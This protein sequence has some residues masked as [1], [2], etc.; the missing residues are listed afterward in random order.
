MRFKRQLSTLCIALTAVLFSACADIRK[1]TYP[2]EITYI[3]RNELRSA[4][5]RM[6]SALQQL[7]ALIVEETSVEPPHQKIMHQLGTIEHA[8]NDL[9]SGNTVTNHKAIDEHMDQFLADV[10]KARLMANASPPNYYYAGRLSGSCG[11]CHQFR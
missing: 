8:A 9:A 11:A 3:D 10:A 7:D 1:L 6:A 4:M 2:P 5:Y